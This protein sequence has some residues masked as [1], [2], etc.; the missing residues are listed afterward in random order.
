MATEIDDLLKT[1]KKNEA[2]EAQYKVM[3]ANEDA[4]ESLQNAF[5]VQSDFL[6]DIVEYNE[7]AI[8]TN[9]ILVSGMGR[10]ISL[11]ERQADMAEIPPIPNDFDGDMLML[12][13][14]LLAQTTVIRGIM[15][16]M[17]DRQA[18]MD[19]KKTWT[20]P[21][22]SVP[23][24]EKVKLKDRSGEKGIMGLLAEI[25][26]WAL[27]PVLAVA[28]YMAR[29]WKKLKIKVLKKLR[30][31]KKK[32]ATT[33]DDFILRAKTFID[34]VVE[35]LAK[36][37]PKITNFMKTIGGFFKRI[38]GS[39][40][41]KW[42]AKG[43]GL[44]AKLGLRVVGQIAALGGKIL[45]KVIAPIIA[46]YDFFDGWFNADKITG[47]AKDSLSI[48]DKMSA[49]LASI[50]SGLT[51]GFV[52]AQ[53]WYD[54]IFGDY[55][56]VDMVKGFFIDIW[57]MLPNGIRDAAKGIWDGLTVLT[58][59][60]SGQF[61]DIFGVT[62]SEK[63]EKIF[64][65]MAAWFNEN[66]SWAKLKPSWLPSFGGDDEKELDEKNAKFNNRKPIMLDP[67][68]VRTVAK[69]LDTSTKAMSDRKSINAAQTNNIPLVLQAPAPN[70]IVPGNEFMP[71]A[72]DG[73]LFM[74][75]LQR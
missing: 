21:A 14:G 9:Q 48:W 40:L 72:F 54:V 3:G 11:M 19:D 45:G 29:W 26:K 70:V 35:G 66:I 38:F 75:Q 20:N 42:V 64:D 27:A 37:F 7:R 1:L 34:E 28:K 73:D 31:V 43:I 13:K 47:I 56:I 22:E 55:G 32:I 60:I 44:F 2:I 49:G 51:L 68:S 50:L 25:G 36:R 67:V 4:S 46:I 39:G 53:D 71:S 59:F 16:E 24:K 30:D 62:I 65:D 69:S 10:I 61:K 41:T 18:K 23:D 15:E 17:K 58:D 74:Q 6:S 8:T 12:T 57:N 33:I 63:I 52:T 5:T